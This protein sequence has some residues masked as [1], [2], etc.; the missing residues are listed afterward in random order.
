MNLLSTL[1]SGITK[2]G[3][4]EPIA[5]AEKGLYSPTLLKSDKERSWRAAT[6]FKKK[7][8]TE[9]SS[10]AQKLRM[11][12]R[13]SFFERQT[14]Q[15][16]LKPYA[17]HQ[18]ARHTVEPSYDVDY[19]K[20]N[21]TALKKLKT[22]KKSEMLLFNAS[23]GYV[24]EMIPLL[25][26]LTPREATMSTA[27]RR[28][29][30][31]V[32][33]EIPP[34]PDFAKQ[35]KTFGT[36]IATLTHSRFYYK[37]STMLNGVIPKILRN[38]IHPSN[39]KT[40]ELRNVDVFNDVIFFFSER[41]D[42]A[43]CRELF[44][45]MKLENV[46]PN[47]KT[48]NLMLRNVL[49]KS[50]IRSVKNPLS[51]A[52]YYLRQMQHHD[53]QADAV[54]WTTCYNLLME[55]LSRGVFLEKLLERGV[56]ITPPLVLAILRSE[57]L[58]SSQLLRFL[59]SNYVPLDTK[60]FNF[61]LKTLLI[62]KKYDTA[63][64]FV[65]HAHKNAAFKLNHECLNVFLRHFAE[66]GRLDLALLTFN[67]AITTYG[68]TTNLHSFDMLAK[69]LSRNGYT[70]NFP[71]VLEH[72]RKSKRA[73]TDEVQVFSYWLSK[74]QAI[75]KFNIQRQ[76]TDGD[77]ERTRAILQNARWDSKG[78]RWDCWNDCSPSLRKVFRFLGCVPQD[79]KAKPKKARFTTGQVSSEKKHK[80]KSRVRMLAVRHAMLKRVPYAEDRYA[81]LKKE[82]QERRIIE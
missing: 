28:F 67:S 19:A 11:V 17:A 50:H 30:S 53:I 22:S 39:F 77:L 5:V 69:A 34:I 44:A 60:L 45:Q 63:W 26:L 15:E 64:A 75:S 76:V 13:G 68:I 36:Y 41:S 7:T 20:A 1:A 32:F 80:Y 2:H 78:M 74:A 72:L 70:R 46:T 56:P 73:Y 14:A 62:E 82:L 29:R 37:K 33:T 21:Y 54:T 25:V 57:D 59:T 48:L 61:C 10:S 79:I 9:H 23:K 81:A 49:K 47:T 66:K 55:S 18:F 65:D 42:Y 6:P 35:P 12:G 16:F 8:T 43:T 38:L 58:N 27:K 40:I 71:L 4:K 31:E 52:L 3:L 51:E 24:E